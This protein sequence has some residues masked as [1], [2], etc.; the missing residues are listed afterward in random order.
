[1]KSKKDRDGVGGGGTQR[2]GRRGVETEE[3]E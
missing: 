3:A 1:M 2:E